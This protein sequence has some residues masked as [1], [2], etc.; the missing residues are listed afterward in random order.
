MLGMDVGA[1]AGSAG[2]AGGSHFGCVKSEGLVRHP[3]EDT[4]Q[5]GVETSTR[6]ARLVGEDCPDTSTGRRSKGV[7][8]CYLHR[9]N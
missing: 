7:F 3:R 9:D 5:H 8:G 1:G 2:R 6:S 4:G